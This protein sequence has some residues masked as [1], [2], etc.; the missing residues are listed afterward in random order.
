MSKMQFCIC[1]QSEEHGI[2]LHNFMT[3]YHVKFQC[4]PTIV[5]YTL[6][7]NTFSGISIEFCASV[8]NLGMYVSAFLVKLLLLMLKL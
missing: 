7:F 2:I 3:L 4:M 8:F 5:V 1:K 6:V